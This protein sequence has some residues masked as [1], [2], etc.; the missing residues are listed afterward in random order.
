MRQYSL[1]PEKYWGI[2]HAIRT[3]SSRAQ[4]HFAAVTTC[5]DFFAAADAVWDALMF[6]EEIAEA[7]PF[8]SAVSFQ[9]RPELRVASLKLEAT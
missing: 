1:H 2:R 6:N 9:F 7:R 4:E 8:L 5:Q 3:E